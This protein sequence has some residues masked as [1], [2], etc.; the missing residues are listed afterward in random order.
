VAVL[1]SAMWWP[2][3]N[4]AGWPHESLACFR[5]ST[6]RA[7]F[8]EGSWL[9]RAMLPLMLR[10]LPLPLLLIALLAGIQFVV[11]WALGAFGGS[12]HAF[13]P[14]TVDRSVYDP[15]GALSSEAEAA[16]EARIDAIEQRSGAELAIFVRIAPDVT[17]DSNL[18]DARRLMDEWG[19]GRRG[20]DDG[21]VIL[22]SYFDSTFEH[23]SLSTYA[24][25]GFKAVYF[26][27][28]PQKALRE[29]TIIP[30]LRQGSLDSGLL[31]AVEQ[32]GAAITPEATSRLETY[33]TI[34]GLVGLPGG[35]LALV[36]TLGLAFFTW[37]RYG[38]D[39]DLTDSP[40]ILMAGPPADMTPALA[41]VVRAG[42]ATQ[43]SIN[44]A[45]VDLAASGYIAFR[46]LDQVRKVKSDDDPN[47]L[48]DPAIDVLQLPHDRK[49]LG[50]AEAEV[51]EAIRGAGHGDGIVSR[52]SLWRLNDELDP[53]KAS[54]EEEA[55]RIGWLS[56]RPSPMITRWTVIGVGELVFGGILVFFGYT[57]PMS[58]LTLLGF[59]L[60]V[61]GIG[62]V[63]F[64][65][66]MSQRTTKGAYVDSML[67]AYRRTLQKTLQQARD[68][69]QVV[70]QPEVRM[71]ADTSDKAVAWGI[72]LGLH[73]EVAEVLE[74][75]L[76]D[77]RE[78]VGQSG[79]YYP[80]W[81]GSGS[82][83]SLS[84]GSLGGSEGGLGGLFS[85]S[86]TPDIGGM[87]SS[88]G[89]MGSSP[90]SSSSSSSGGGFGGG[91][92]GGGGGGSSGF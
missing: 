28:D 76:A 81:L 5:P 34:N 40:S 17:D 59:A 1:K 85:G 72:A 31:V 8:D 78:A 22:L 56:R 12:G 15:A 55:V 77:R 24:G 21:F 63:A 9:G 32:V 90:A 84:G 87:F 53:V 33:R 79:G 91:G 35:M 3:L 44:T 83:S 16:L 68:M 58:G 48:I 60:G 41:T 70:Q 69:N 19:V 80:L 6:L 38:D 20:F 51:Y 66:A 75:S 57:I 11:P 92:G 36:L 82:S 2:A 64:G 62:T 37:R 10:R 71:L 89:S 14:P 52:G 47:P 86:G 4:G 39:P 7:S 23:G 26:S 54:L 74:R 61:G 30:A 88:L 46:N 73:R 25:S 29:G 45:L 50:R 13:P 42:R 67:K 43:E 27:E 65:N 49:R 18:A